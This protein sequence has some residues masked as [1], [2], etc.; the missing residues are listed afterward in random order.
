MAA[1]AGVAQEETGEHGG[2]D[3]QPD[4]DGQEGEGEERLGGVEQAGDPEILHGGGRV[5]VLLVGDEFGEAPGHLH[6][7]EGD[8]E[9]HDAQPGDEGA[10]DE[11][12]ESRDGYGGGDG[13]QR[14]KVRVGVNELGAV[15][16]EVEHV[17]GGDHGQRDG[18][19]GG[20]VDA[21]GDDDEGHADGG[22]GDDGDVLQHELGV[23]V[24]HEALA[25]RGEDGEE[26]VHGGERGEAAEHGEHAGGFLRAAGGGG[27]GVVGRGGDGSGGLGHF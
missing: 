8:D 12:D 1:E 15:G 7:A 23:G 22:H 18:G 5:D 19:A 20:E 11:A 17:G 25:R 4:G 13:E 16:A 27:G 2:A 21:A 10:V 24:G 3:D 9:G 6:A 26:G 14:E